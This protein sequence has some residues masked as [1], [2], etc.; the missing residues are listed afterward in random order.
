M[1]RGAKWEATEKGLFTYNT[2]KPCSNGHISDRYTKSGG[3]I[4]CVKETARMFN[5]RNTSNII[6]TRARLDHETTLINLFVH[7]NDLLTVKIIL[8]D[9][10]TKECPNLKPGYVNPGQ[11]SG[12]QIDLGIYQV[13]VRVPQHSV[14]AIMDISKTLLNFSTGLIKKPELPIVEIEHQEIDIENI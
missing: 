6:E 12:R 9:I 7:Q 1:Q 13:K 10:V 4:E 5:A 8:D 14:K 11:L 2:G 3:C